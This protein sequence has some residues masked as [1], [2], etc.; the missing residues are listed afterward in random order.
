MGR[1]EPHKDAPLTPPTLATREIV[2]PTP[3][4]HGMK[5]KLELIE[6]YNK[7]TLPWQRM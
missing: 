4:A 5:Q 3:P 1:Q 7:S 6:T 2:L